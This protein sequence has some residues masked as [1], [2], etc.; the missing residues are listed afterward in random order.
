MSPLVLTPLIDNSKPI[1]SGVPLYRGISDK[2]EGT[3]I[4]PRN[5]LQ[6]NLDSPSEI[7]RLIFSEQKPQTHILEIEKDGHFVSFSLQREVACYY[8]TSD[9]LGDYVKA[10][11]IVAVRFPDIKQR[12]TFGGSEPYIF[13]C[14][15]GTVW[16][17]MRHLPT[18]WLETVSRTMVDHELL[19][20]RGR[21]QVS[22][23]KPITPEE[24][25]KSFLPWS[26]T[27]KNIELLNK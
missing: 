22:E 12:I 7:V 10:G 19:L 2:E 15:G 24:C 21:I 6:I 13:E 1:I 16:L 4:S 26:R 8:A 5:P 27:G 20:L 14:F 18:Q 11:R 25:D 3:V 9:A 23:L 17:D